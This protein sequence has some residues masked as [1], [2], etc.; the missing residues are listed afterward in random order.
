LF[1]KFCI[2]A[3]NKPFLQILP[4]LFK[5]NNMNKKEL[6]IK[7]ADKFN[8]PKAQGEEIVKFILSTITDVIKGGDEMMLTG[9]GAFSSRKRG[10]RAGVNPQEPSERIHIPTVIVP[11]FK[12]GKSLKD[13]LKK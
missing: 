2:L 4:K 6:G 8:L 12:A 3:Q 7:I 11:K 1:F 10:A 13:A 5:T 9:F